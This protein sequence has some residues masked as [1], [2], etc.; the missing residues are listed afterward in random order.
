[1]ANKFHVDLFGAP[2]KPTYAYQRYPLS[3]HRGVHPNVE[4]RKALS[5]ED[6]QEARSNGWT[7]EPP[8]LP[9]PEPE[10]KAAVSLEERVN[11]LQAEMEELKDVIAELRAV[12]EEMRSTLEAATAP[13]KP[14]V[15]KRGKE[16]K[17]DA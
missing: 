13:A 12:V 6:E 16:E 7:T 5:E 9:E 15:G 10:F 1:M 11:D 17:S 14:A 4:S 2:I 8:K 3:M